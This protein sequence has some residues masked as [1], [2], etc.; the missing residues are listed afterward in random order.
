[1][2]GW[3]ARPPTNG[4]RV[5]GGL[6]AGGRRRDRP[7]RDRREAGDLERPTRIL[8]SRPGRGVRE[9]AST[10]A[11]IVGAARRRVWTT[12]AYFAPR[13]GASGS[14]A[15][16][17]PGGSCPPGLPREDR[18]SSSLPTPCHG[19]FPGSPA[20][21]RLYLRVSAG[22]SCTP[23][24]WSR[25]ARSSVNGSTNLY[26][27][28][29][30]MQRRA[31][32]RDHGRRDRRPHGEPARGRRGEQPG[33]PPV[34]VEAAFLSSPR[35]PWRGAEAGGAAPISGPRTGRREP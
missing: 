6:E 17:R 34:P 2:P 14:C 15:T 19:F 26:F 32:L 31:Q 9:T 11:A 29:F 20:A 33:D 8:D 28:S 7:S 12:M 25:R 27:R 13:R 24:P 16:R 5:P 18:R 3:Q 21:R 4:R 30:E 10:L 22:R 35:L 23:R 1:M